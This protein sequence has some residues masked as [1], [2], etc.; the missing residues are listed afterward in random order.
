M[1]FQEVKVA[2]VA[3]R[4]CRVEANEKEGLERHTVNKQNPLVRET[5]ATV[6]L[7]G[8]RHSCS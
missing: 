7:Q 5:L 6:C 1:I 4:C 3:E 2:K 8:A